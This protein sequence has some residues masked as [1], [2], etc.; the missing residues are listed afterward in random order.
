VPPISTTAIKHILTV[1]TTLLKI[2]LLTWYICLAAA[3]VVDWT[4]YFRNQL[5]SDNYLLNEIQMF[6]DQFQDLET[7]GIRNTLK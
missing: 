4:R 3:I 7:L 6:K 1:V 2:V 5:H